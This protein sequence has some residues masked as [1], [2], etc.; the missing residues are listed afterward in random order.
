MLRDVPLEAWGQRRRRRHCGGALCT[1]ERVLLVLE[2]EGRAL[3]LVA[4]RGVLV[5]DV[6]AY[7]DGLSK[8]S[9]GNASEQINWLPSRAWDT[10]P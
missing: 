3:R 1:R 8:R 4:H 7:E 9:G 10:P 2:L 6:L 5:I